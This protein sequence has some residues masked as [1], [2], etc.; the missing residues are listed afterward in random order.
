MKLTRTEIIAAIAVAV[1]GLALVVAIL[2][3]SWRWSLALLGA[4]MVLLAAVVVLVL[5]R[6]D[7]TRSADL[8]RLERKVD[9][10]AL[11]VVT[12]SQATHR[13]LSGLIEQLGAD[14][15]RRDL[16]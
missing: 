10:V 14:L 15:G 7:A 16:S 1:I 13:E 3:D 5:R 9:N 11:R 6:Q 12:E 2:M 8:E 4:L